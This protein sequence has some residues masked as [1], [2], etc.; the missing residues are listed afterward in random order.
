[1]SEAV[2]EYPDFLPSVAA[3][4]RGVVRNPANRFERGR[5]WTDGDHLDQQIEEIRN[6]SL[7]QLPTVSHPDLSAT[8]INKVNPRNSPD[9]GFRWTIN[10]YRGCEHGCVYCYARPTH[11]FLGWTCGIDFE[12]QIMV[13]HNAAKLLRSELSRRSWKG[14][15][16]VMSGVTDPYQPLERDF[17]I[18]RS[19]LEVM[20]E[21]NQSV[22]LVTKSALVL[23]DLE[24]LQSLA[25]DNL[26]SVAVSLTTL[27]PGLARIMEPRASHPKERLKAIRGLSE[28][29]VPVV[30]LTAPMIPGIN[31]HELPSLLAAAAE[32][33]AT[34]AG[35]VMLRLPHQLKSLF[36]TWLQQHFPQR[37]RKVEAFIRDVRGGALYDPTSGTRMRGEGAHA[38]RLARTFDVFAARH[39]LDR[40]VPHL[41]QTR[42]RRP[43][44]QLELYA[45]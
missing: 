36:L 26:V 15:T 44:S 17:Y 33:G 14:E 43:R 13:K 7:P 9:I 31:D 40:P 39:G 18:T 2:P 21:F 38:E 34:S 22:G 10:P 11:E 42:F 20:R 41:D 4:G 27:D 19:C 23:R 16:I 32:A 12:T 8:I 28:A 6:H 35:W 30:V 37:A 24:L 1:M 29:G 5:I 3:K 25:S 45:D